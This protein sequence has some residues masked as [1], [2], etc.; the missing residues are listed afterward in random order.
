MEPS[1]DVLLPPP[2]S[3]SATR[4]G[5]NSVSARQWHNR[6]TAWQARERRQREESAA[7]EAEKCR[8]FGESDGTG[9]D[10]GLCLKMLE[11]FGGLDFIDG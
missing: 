8:I 5:V 6:Y 10:E 2:L 7:L 1:I 3:R 9:E 4:P 11:Y